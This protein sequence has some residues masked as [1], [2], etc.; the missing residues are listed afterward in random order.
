MLT[1]RLPPAVE[2]SRLQR[3]KETVLGDEP[4]R[5]SSIIATDDWIA[6]VDARLA[7]LERAVMPPFRTNPRPMD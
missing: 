3:L 5:Q 7:D 6:E 2:F 4:K 1:S